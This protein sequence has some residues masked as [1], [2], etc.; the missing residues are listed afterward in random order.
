[1]LRLETEQAVPAQAA[2]LVFPA[3]A[4]LG[5][6]GRWELDSCPSCHDCRLLNEVCGGRPAAVG[7]WGLVLW[8]RT[9]LRVPGW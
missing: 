4:I 3:Q 7:T 1:M 6:Q 5:T 8:P 2:L 9:G